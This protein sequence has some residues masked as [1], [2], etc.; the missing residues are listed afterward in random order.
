MQELVVQK[1]TLSRFADYLARQFSQ[2]VLD[3]TGLEGDYSFTLHWIPDVN[4]PISQLDVFGPAG[5]RAME[6]QLGLRLEPIRT[7]VEVLVIDRIERIPTE[8]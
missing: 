3:K 6:D 7:P 5:S 4:P 8:N 2:P 1:N